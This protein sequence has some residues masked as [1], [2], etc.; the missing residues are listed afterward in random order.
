MNKLP[1]YIV[2]GWNREQFYTPYEYCVTNSLSHAQEILRKAIREKPGQLISVEYH[3]YKLDAG[4]FSEIV[5]DNSD[6]SFLEEAQKIM[7]AADCKNTIN[8]EIGYKDVTNG[9]DRFGSIYA[10][11]SYNFD[12][13]TKTIKLK[14]DVQVYCYNA[15]NGIR[16]RARQ[17]IYDSLYCVEIPKIKKALRELNSDLRVSI[18]DN[19]NCKIV[20]GFITK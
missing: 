20:K 18:I 4:A 12:S 10:H 11:K 15:T 14:V 17:E 2:G 9:Q 16:E 1:V 6:L 3:I 5:S 8:N 13:K 19:H 7:D